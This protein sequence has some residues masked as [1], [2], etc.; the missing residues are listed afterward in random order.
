M[1][2]RTEK[3]RS[4]PR[5]TDKS[6]G[7]K[8]GSSSTLFGKAAPSGVQKTRRTSPQKPL[9]PGQET[10]LI[11]AFADGA[12]LRPKTTLSPS[13]QT[14]FNKQ[15][16]NEHGEPA[17]LQNTSGADEGEEVAPK[18]T[19]SRKPGRPPGA[20]K[21]PTEK[22]NKPPAAQLDAAPNK[23]AYQQEIPRARNNAKPD[24]AKGDRYEILHEDGETGIFDQ[25]E[26]FGYLSHY[27]DLYVE[28]ADMQGKILKL[29]E[30]HFGFVVDDG[31]ATNYLVKLSKEMGK[32]LVRYAGFIAVGG[33]AAVAGWEEIFLTA[34]L[35]SAL[36]AGVIWQALKQH[37]LESLWYG[38]SEEQLRVLEQGEFDMK[39]DE[40][41]ECIL[42]WYNDL[43]L[44]LSTGFMRN[45]KR[46]K[47]LRAAGSKGFTKSNKDLPDGQKEKVELIAGIRIMLNPLLN[48]PPQRTLFQDLA[49]IVDIAIKLNHAMRLDSTTIYNWATTPKDQVYD[50]GLVRISSKAHWD[51]LFDK[52][53]RSAYT[54]ADPDNGLD[55]KK[56]DRIKRYGFL[57]RVVVFDP[58]EA[59]Q[60]GGWRKENEKIG[61]RRKLICKGAVAARW[62]A[63]RKVTEGNVE[64]EFVELKD[65]HGQLGSASKVRW[66]NLS[67]LDPAW[68]EGVVNVPVLGENGTGHQRSLQNFKPRLWSTI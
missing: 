17:D 66:W 32:E 30:D 68:G 12:H 35:R 28:L 40:C 59:Y 18:P 9:A 23:P 37:V 11:E 39:S 16:T 57:S 24:P 61:Q 60:K 21:K 1:A 56:V 47:A 26:T 67:P 38:A 10:Y 48:K 41:G 20:N 52:R 34:E 4:S 50:N 25:R 42:C 22:E 15:T 33:P 14:R 51:H 65:C 64:G 13:K 62:G 29:S 46:V 45:D 5:K 7:A 44:T 2:P 3:A 36:A 53:Y 54:K 55:E 6:S 8:S 19:S 27:N 31:D 43:H 63:T 58:L 49:L